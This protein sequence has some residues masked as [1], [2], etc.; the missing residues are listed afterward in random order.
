MCALPVL[1][2][3]RL[4]FLVPVRT[5]DSRSHNAINTMNTFANETEI[6]VEK[7]MLHSLIMIVV[8]VAYTLILTKTIPKKQF[9]RGTGLWRRC[10]LLWRVADEKKNV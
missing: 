6:M 8:T 1:S 9:I 10:I 2:M 7:Q 5:G 4:S 3:V